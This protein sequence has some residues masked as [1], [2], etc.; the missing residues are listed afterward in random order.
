[1]G[2][3]SKFLPVI[4]ENSLEALQALLPR[5]VAGPEQALRTRDLCQ[6]FRQGA[7]AALLRTGSSET[8]Q[9]RLQRSGSAYLAHLAVAPRAD[10]R[11]SRAV[12]FFDALGAGDEATAQAIAAQVTDRWEPT[13]EAEDDYLYVHAAMRWLGDAPTPE[14]DALLARWEACLQGDE[15]LR[16]ET[17]RALHAGDADALVSL[18][19]A[20]TRAVARE[21]KDDDAAIEVLTTEAVVSVEALA[22]LALAGRAG[23]HVG[24]G[25]RA[26]PAL[27]RGL[28][29]QSW[30]R[31]AHLTID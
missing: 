10:Q 31:D 22:I 4:E 21:A 9:R 24:D 18:L 11:R 23:V 5:W 1:M 27:A 19:D 29:P 26:A 20:H 6:H 30:S 15:D 8:F 25:V 16:L 12:P 3:G 28:P 7:I 14:K 2:R 13:S 17:F